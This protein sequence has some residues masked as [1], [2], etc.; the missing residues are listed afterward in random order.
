MPPSVE[1]WPAPLWP[2]LRTASSRP[3]SRARRSTARRRP[4]RRPGRSRPDGVEAAGHDRAGRVVVGVVRP[5]HAAGDGGLDLRDQGGR[6][7]GAVDRV[8]EASSV[9]LAGER[10]AGWWWS[11]APRR[12]KPDGA[13]CRAYQAARYVSRRVVVRLACRSVVIV[14]IVRPRSPGR[15]PGA[16][17]GRRRAARVVPPRSG[18]IAPAGCDVAKWLGFELA[19]PPL[20]VPAL[21]DEPGVLGA[22]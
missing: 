17:A 7:R 14:V 20:G 8:H 21:D 9:R 2:P 18:G 6:C 22:P 3:V 19:W 13:P 16:R 11:E 15:P 5:D 12:A 1:L 10:P 4:R